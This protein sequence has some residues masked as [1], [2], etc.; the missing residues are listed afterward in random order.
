MTPNAKDCLIALNDLSAPDG[1]LCLHFKTIM[2]ATGLD[3][4]M[5]R[6]QVRALA[7]KGLAEYFRGLF[8]EDGEV[9]GAGYCIT[10]EG[11]KTIETLMLQL[12]I[13]QKASEA[14]DGKE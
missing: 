7:R 6:F 14:P 3:R 2:D 10:K 9:A 4:K 13:N 1:E 12:D 8:T 5:V 11:M